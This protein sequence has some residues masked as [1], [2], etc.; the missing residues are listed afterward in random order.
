[1]SSLAALVK[2][3]DKKIFYFFNQRMNC[4]MLNVIMRLFTHIG[5][6]AFSFALPII[7][8]LL[9]SARVSNVGKSMAVS[10][11]VAQ[12][13]VQSV[14][15]LVNRP[16]PYVTIE[17]I[18]SF[19]P[20]ACKYSFPSGHTSAAFSQAFALS[21]MFKGAALVFIPIAVIVGISRMYLGYHYPTDV[22]VGG[23]ISFIAFFISSTFIIQYIWV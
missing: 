5:S 15:R 8:I 10:L 3:G 19:N 12:L 14:K 13:I 4:K 16:R 7:L 11:A 22:F 2:S 1:M 9:G 23:V 20:P 18:L 21:L 6:T 17:S